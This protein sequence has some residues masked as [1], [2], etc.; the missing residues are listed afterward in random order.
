MSEKIDFLS[1]NRDAIT[2]Y[3]LALELA[4]SVSPASTAS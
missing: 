3:L 2:A 4:S 1:H